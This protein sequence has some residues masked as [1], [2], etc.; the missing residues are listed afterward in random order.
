[1]NYQ[2]EKKLQEKQETQVFK[3]AVVIST[4]ETGA[5]IKFDGQETSG[6]KEYKKLYDL[7]IA[8]G[9]RVICGRCSGTYVVL[10]RLKY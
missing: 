9:D 8:P 5:V 7:T 1:M 6:G 3:M 10:G 4:T 2:E